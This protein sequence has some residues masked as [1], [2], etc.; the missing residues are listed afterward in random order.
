LENAPAQ[1]NPELETDR[2]IC[3][4]RI[5]L[6]DDVANRSDARRAFSANLAAIEGGQLHDGRWKRIIGSTENTELYKQ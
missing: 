4:N 5:G 2:A 6:K 1:A 3:G